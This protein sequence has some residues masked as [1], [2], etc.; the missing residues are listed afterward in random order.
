METS[1]TWASLDW[2]HEVSKKAL[3]SKVV[4]TI[5]PLIVT[6][7]STIFKLLGN[8]MTSL[9]PCGTLLATVKFMLILVGAPSS[10]VSFYYSIFKL[11]IAPFTVF[12]IFKSF[13]A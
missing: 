11:D 3:W 2:I 5:I 6:T 8:T 12:F 7:G 4:T 10:L 13:F 1:K 9:L